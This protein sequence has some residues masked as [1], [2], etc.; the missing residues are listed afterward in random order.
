MNVREAAE[1]LGVSTQALY[2]QINANDGKGSG[3]GRFFRKNN[4]GKTVID[5]R[6][7]LDENHLGEHSDAKE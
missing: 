7:I 6:Y 5:D 3:I 4:R 2:K 1:E